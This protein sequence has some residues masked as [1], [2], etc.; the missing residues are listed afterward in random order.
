MLVA[1]HLVAG[2]GV[3]DLALQ[4]AAALVVETPV[5]V[6]L[7]RACPLGGGPT[8]LLSHGRPEL[9]VRARVHAGGSLPKLALALR[10]A[11]LVSGGQLLVQA[12]A[13]CGRIGELL[14]R[15]LRPAQ[16][17]LQVLGI[18]GRLGVAAVRGFAEREG[19]TAE[20]GLLTMTLSGR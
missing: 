12:G 20:P 18:L 16:P 10:G 11:L 7:L 1:R 13:L 3:P 5:R 6:P 9:P 2:L 17:R 15:C 4:V 8:S 14:L 19:A